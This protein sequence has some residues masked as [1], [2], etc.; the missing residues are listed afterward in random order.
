MHFCCPVL[1]DFRIVLVTVTENLDNVTNGN[2]P[3]DSLMFS[4]RFFD[5]T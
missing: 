3:T 4:L 2:L 5:K 1:S